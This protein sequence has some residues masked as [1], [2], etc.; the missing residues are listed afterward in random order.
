MISNLWKQGRGKPFKIEW[1]YIKDKNTLKFMELLLDRFFEKSIGGEKKKN[2]LSGMYWVTQTISTLKMRQTHAIF[3]KTNLQSLVQRLSKS[4]DKRKEKL[5]GLWAFVSRRS[6]IIQSR[7][8]VSQWCCSLTHPRSAH[9]LRVI[10]SQGESRLKTHFDTIKYNLGAK[11]TAKIVTQTSECGTDF[12]KLLRQNFWL[13]G[14]Y[15]FNLLEE[16]NPFEEKKGVGKS[17]WTNLCWSHG[18]SF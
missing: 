11:R 16:F 12:I 5:C 18:V 13:F 10:W 9:F 3:M 4:E 17:Q 14:Q 1:Q 8:N 2:E 7:S 6:M 15:S